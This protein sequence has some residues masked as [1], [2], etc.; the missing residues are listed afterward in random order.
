MKNSLL[1]Q[2]MEKASM[3]QAFGSGLRETYWLSLL[4]SLDANKS[5]CNPGYKYE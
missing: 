2:V 5:I 4:F 1:S 3:A